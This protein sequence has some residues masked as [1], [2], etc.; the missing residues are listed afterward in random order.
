MM[1]IDI[2]NKLLKPDRSARRLNARLV[3]GKALFNSEKCI[4]R[5]GA[6]VVGLAIR[7]LNYKGK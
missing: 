4:A 5:G 3:G 6:W 1:Y 7:V 2:Y